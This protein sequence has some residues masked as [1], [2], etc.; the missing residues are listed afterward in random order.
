MKSTNKLIII[1]IVLLIIA[2]IMGYFVYQGLKPNS[3]SNSSTRTTTEVTHVAEVDIEYTEDEET[4]WFLK[5]LIG[6]LI[7]YVDILDVKVGCQSLMT[8]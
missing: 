8:G 1:L 2:G 7:S 5:L 3:T 6:D 4:R